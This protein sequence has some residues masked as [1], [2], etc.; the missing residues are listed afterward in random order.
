MNKHSQNAPDPHATVS[1]PILK[2]PYFICIVLGVLIMFLN[3]AP[4][5]ILN[6]MPFLKSLAKS[7]VFVEVLIGMITFALVLVTCLFLTKIASK[8]SLNASLEEI[9]WTFSKYSIRN[10][11]LGWLL[12]SLAMILAQ[13]FAKTFHFDNRLMEAADTSTPTLVTITLISAFGRG[14]L[15]QGMPEE[16]IW[17]GWM[18]NCL[19]NR[20]IKSL[21]LSSLFFALLHFLSS[22]GQENFI[23]RVIY[24]F[25]AAAF[26]FLAGALALRL[27]SLWPAFGVHGGLHL[28]NALLSMTPF[29]IDGPIIWIT[30]SILW[31]IIGLTLLKNFKGKTVNYIY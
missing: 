25:D 1:T 4:L 18:M 19:K 24:V 2:I 22:G 11:C 21:I 20:P 27:K 29:R 13:A 12:V 5:I 30:Q 26:A 16:I 8:H 15:M 6:F 28:T 31:I 3:Y 14:V 17:R 23:E 10:F 7:H 9:G